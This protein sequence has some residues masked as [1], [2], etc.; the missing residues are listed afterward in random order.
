MK[1][2]TPEQ[3]R[4]LRTRNHITQDELADSLYGIK[5]ARIGDWEA[6]RRRMP[7]IVWWACKLTWD[8]VDLW[9]EE[10]GG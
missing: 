8:K 5:R 2:P 9:N 10:H 1:N 6:G 3:I 4:D 7:I